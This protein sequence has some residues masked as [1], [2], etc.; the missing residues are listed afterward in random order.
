MERETLDA[1]EIREVFRDVPKWEHATNGTM[2]I[3][4]PTAQAGGM[5]VALPRHRRREPAHTP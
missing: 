1:D 2:R 5:V 4:I 3:Q